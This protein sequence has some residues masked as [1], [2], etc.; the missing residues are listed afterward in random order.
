MGTCAQDTAS[1]LPR[2]IVLWFVLDAVVALAP[3]LH[4]AV[5]EQRY[6]VLG[7]PIAV[8]YFVAVGVFI[9]VSLVAAFCVDAAHEEVR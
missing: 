2:W 1:R 7:L 8:F 6:P 9:S 3:P 5:S 4:R